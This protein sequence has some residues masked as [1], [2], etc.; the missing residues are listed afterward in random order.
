MTEITISK[1]LQDI[2]QYIPTGAIFADIGSDHAYLPVFVCLHD[3]SAQAIAGEINKGPYLSALDQVT[4]WG[5]QDRISVRMGDGLA[6]IDPGEVVQLVIAG[7][8]GSLITSIL[9]NGKDKLSKVERIIAQPNINA[10]NVRKWLARHGYELVDER[11]IEEDGYHYEILVADKSKNPSLTYSEKEYYLG[12]IM[13]NKKDKDF[14]NKWTHVLKKKQEIVKQMQNAQQPDTR[15]I[16]QFE[17]E[18]NWIEE[19]L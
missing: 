6:V 1:R 16:I 4:K 15:K 18:I 10:R 12:P 11:V 8:G 14:I 17:K 19:E 7:M 13:L 5:L 3:N 9:D 2:A